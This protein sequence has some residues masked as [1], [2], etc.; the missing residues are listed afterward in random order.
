MLADD[1]RIAEL[2][3]KI[4]EVEKSAQQ[5]P[6]VLAAM[7]AYREAK[8]KSRTTLRETMERLDP[9]VSGIITEVGKLENAKRSS[10]ATP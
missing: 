5:D 6:N 1:S 3:T 2:K 10:K 4:K 7:A 8:T 9:G